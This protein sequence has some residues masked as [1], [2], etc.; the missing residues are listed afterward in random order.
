M[1]TDTT[2]TTKT[3]E[4]TDT[5]VTVTVKSKRGSGTRDQD[6]VTVKAHYDDLSDAGTHV[7]HMNS[8]LNYQLDKARR[9]DPANDR[10][11]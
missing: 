6:T 4:N 9:N 3:I 7:E 11:D 5:G 2:E 10:D 8:V 1:N